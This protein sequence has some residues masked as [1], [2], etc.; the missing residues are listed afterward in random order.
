MPANKFLF[1]NKDPTS[2]S[3]SNNRSEASLAYS[4]I[5]KHVQKLSA[6]QRLKH[7]SDSLITKS[8]AQTLVGWHEATPLTPPLTV[9][10]ESVTSGGDQEYDELEDYDEE[11]R[12][13][14]SDSSSNA[15]LLR[16]AVDSLP[17]SVVRIDAGRHQ[18]LQYFLSVWMPSATHIP[19]GCQ[20]AGYTPIWPNDLELSSRVMQGAMQTDHELS[21][22]SLLAA[23]SRRM[24]SLHRQK[25]DQPGLPEMQTLQAVQALRKRAASSA[26]LDERLILDISYLILA[27]LYAEIPSRS[28][29][30][31]KIIRDL[32]VRF[33]GLQNL[34][35]FVTQAALAYD[36]FNSMGTLTMPA[37][38]PLHDTALLGIDESVPTVR[39]KFLAQDQLSKLEPRLRI[40]AQIKHAFAKVLCEIHTLPAP[41]IADLKDLISHHVPQ[42][43][44]VLAGPF[45]QVDTQPSVSPNHTGNLMTADTLSI[46]T[47]N[48]LCHAWLWHTALGCTGVVRKSMDELDPWAHAHE[49][50][51]PPPH[52]RRASRAAWRQLGRIEEL[53][54]GTGW[55]VKRHLALWQDAIGYLLSVGQE[56]QQA[57][58]ARFVRQ[59]RAMSI[60]D[61][62]GVRSGLASHLP[63]HRIA[64]DW[65]LMLS[66]LLVPRKVVVK[67]EDVG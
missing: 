57:F 3:L 26:P 65:S 12:S 25:F 36:Y 63:L 6:R 24:Q 45:T 60:V 59:A 7:K 1:I 8:A 18:V 58:R 53:L 34:D 37:I 4:K 5:N 52:V 43:Y 42:L 54:R 9:K 20:I 38:D 50:H 19:L 15:P 66:R 23:S 31:Y 11:I 28:E 2:R 51:V 39:A 22:Y 33:D 41:A 32:I 14:S 21:M 55:E 16:G 44:P 13:V 49:K 48:I 35:P 40:T 29:I 67:Q 10:S 62:A 27:D 46:Q 47:R 64:P 17:Q 30:Y 61:E 56:D